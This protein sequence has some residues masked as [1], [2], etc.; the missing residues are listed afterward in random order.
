[1]TFA[2]KWRNNYKTKIVGF[3]LRCHAYRRKTGGRPTGSLT[4]EF[5]CIDTKGKEITYPPEPLEQ[6][7]ASKGRWLPLKVSR[8]I[9]IA[10]IKLLFL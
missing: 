7:K 5:T 8:D 6:G 9:M 3:E 4:T 1:L 10:G 2:E